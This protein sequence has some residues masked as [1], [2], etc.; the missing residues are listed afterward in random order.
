MSAADVNAPLA[1]PGQPRRIP[2][3][4]GG[5]PLIGHSL[6]LLR[7]PLPLL[8][9][10]S[11]YGNLVSV[12]VGPLDLIFIC[13]PALARRVQLDDR[14]FD[15]GGA[16]WRR[17]RE[18]L[19][20]GLLTCPHSRHRRQ[21]RLTQPA[22]NSP[23]MPG[24]AKTI[25]DETAAL[26]ATWHN[27]R[28]VDVVA[29][30]TELSMRIA[31]ATMFSTG[32]PPESRDHFIADLDVLLQGAYRRS[33]TPPAITRLPTPGNRRYLQAGERMRHMLETIV[34][35]RRAR[36]GDR[37]DLLSALLAAR[38]EEA[39]PAVGE[40]ARLSDGEV[41]DQVVTFFTA[42]SET[43][44]GIVQWA[45]HELTKAPEVAERVRA[46]VDEVLAGAP[47]GI[48][49]L[50]RLAETGR[51]VSE[52]LRLYPPGWFVMRQVTADIDLG[53]HRLPAGST[54]VV[55]SYVI[56]NRA[57]LYENPRHFDPARWLDPGRSSPQNDAYFPF[58]MGARKCIGDQFGR[59][60]STLMLADIMAKWRLEAVP[61]HPV[62]LEAGLTLRPAGLKLRAIAR[63]P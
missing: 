50:P 59:L 63:T 30:T 22:F 35:E 57:D 28:L 41:I 18:T 2:R 12:R 1:A 9:S 25:G 45:L 5:L 8:D 38:D 23:R 37:G 19:G 36:G 34:A 44:A 4:S 16:L 56:H 39:D 48:E 24:Y 33:L 10:L 14:T 61:E 60:S 3:A 52:I 21:R 62:R 40:S 58:G 29:E 43:T 27:G 11:A 17:I 51:V 53:G 7:D 26:L 47:A 32:L 20:D 31:L 13:D 15:K 49:H 46:E 42:G 54:L 6:R 55:S